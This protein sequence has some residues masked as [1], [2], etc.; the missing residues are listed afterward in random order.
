MV[1][2]LPIPEWLL[3]LLIHL[4]VPVAGIVL[5][6]WLCRRLYRH[7][8]SP[9]VLL[10]LFPLFCCWGGVLLVALTGLFW[11]WSGMASLG[12]FFLLFASPFIFLPATIAL[13]RSTRRSAVSEAAWYSC[14]FYYV[15]VGSALVL[16]IGP[17]GKR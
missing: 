12:T 10:L 16:F 17:W 3:F 9:T 7:G 6:V 14:L 5:Y 8:E 4:V 1:Y 15:V 13:R 2:R 11:Y